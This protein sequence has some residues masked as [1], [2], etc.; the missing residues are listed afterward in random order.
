MTPEITITSF[1]YRFKPIPNTMEK[2]YDVRQLFNPFKIVG[3]KTGLDP[4]VSDLVMQNGGLEI[5]D[6]IISEIVSLDLKQIA[7]GCK[8]GMHRSVAVACQVAK[9]IEKLGCKAT[10]FHRDIEKIC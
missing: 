9:E 1:G 10:I 5:S 7:I 8:G 4:E 6:K 2:I 3:M